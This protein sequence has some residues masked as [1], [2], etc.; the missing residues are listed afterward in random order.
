MSSLSWAAVSKSSFS[1]ASHIFRS[2]SAMLSLLS[3]TGDAARIPA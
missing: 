3:A 2:I 1:T